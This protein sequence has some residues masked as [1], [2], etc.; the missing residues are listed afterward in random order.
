MPQGKG[1]FRELMRGTVIDEGVAASNVRRLVQRGATAQGPL[2]AR[3]STPGLFATAAQLASCS[4][5]W[6]CGVE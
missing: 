1:G 6:T 2:I 5:R 3:V 4:V